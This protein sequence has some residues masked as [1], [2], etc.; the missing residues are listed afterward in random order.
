MSEER[1]FLFGGRI[2]VVSKVKDVEAAVGKLRE[3]AARSILG[4]YSF[5]G[6]DMEWYTPRLKGWSPS[7]TELM[8]FCSS[9]DLCVLFLMGPL[10]E[11]D[12]VPAILWALLCD[13]EI[14]KVGVPW[15]HAVD[16]VC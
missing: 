7:R 14:K 3:D 15:Y 12:R 11:T 16:E 13:P 10:L 2:E 6:F 5:V 9:P 8:Q 1:Q 4:E